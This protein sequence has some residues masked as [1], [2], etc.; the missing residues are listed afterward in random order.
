LPLPPDTAVPPHDA[1]T[2]PSSS[3]AQSIPS[4]PNL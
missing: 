3:S 2:Q 4:D 1:N